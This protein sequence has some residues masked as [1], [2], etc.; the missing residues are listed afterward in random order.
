MEYQMRHRNRLFGELRR[1]GGTTFEVT[2]EA[3]ARFFDR[4]TKRVDDM[5]LFRGSGVD[6]IPLSD[7]AFD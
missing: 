3:N 5:V 1:R 2:E 4:M 7:Y 6:A